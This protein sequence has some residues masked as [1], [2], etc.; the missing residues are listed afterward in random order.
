M[1]SQSTPSEASP[2]Y[3]R[4]ILINVNPCGIVTYADLVVSTL[5]AARLRAG[6]HPHDICTF[7][8][9]REAEGL[10][11]AV[12]SLAEPP[13]LRDFRGGRGVDG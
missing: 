2:C 13:A 12:L 4:I 3:N 10:A 1:V 8:N 11:P 9:K 7:H 5:A 6:S